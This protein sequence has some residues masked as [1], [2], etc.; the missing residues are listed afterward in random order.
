[1]PSL[2]KEHG[3]NDIYPRNAREA[4]LCDSADTPDWLYLG[5]LVALDVGAVFEQSAVKYSDSQVLRYTGP[6]AVGLTWGAML[7]GGY[8]SLPKC[9]PHWVPGAPREGNVRVTWPMA[10]A[11]AMLSAA[12]APIVA[13]VEYGYTYPETSTLE[14]TGHV[15]TA[16]IAGFVGALLPYALPPKT[17]RAARELEQLRATVDSRSAVLSYSMRF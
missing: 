9:E 7:G 8:L 14:R 5:G 11:V 1:M 6:V 2:A 17:W 4:E 10:L 13:A 3:P 16:S 15:V 12:T